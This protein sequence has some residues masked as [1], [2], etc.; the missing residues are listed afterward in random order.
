MAFSTFFRE[1]GERKQS[2]TALTVLVAGVVAPP[3]LWLL[4]LEAVYVLAYPACAAHQAWWLYPVALAPLPVLALLAVRVS[5]VHHHN[6]FAESEVWPEWTA[7]LALL[8]CATFALVTAAMA[9]PVIW[10]D[11]CL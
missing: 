8:S 2:R 10:L 1:F 3:L 4:A 7:A 9:I 6:P 11:P 5:Q